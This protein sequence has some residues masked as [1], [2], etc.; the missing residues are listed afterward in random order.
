MDLVGVLQT[1]VFGAVYYIKENALDIV[2][3]YLMGKLFDGLLLCHRKEHNFIGDCLTIVGA[4]KKI[5]FILPKNLEKNDIKLAL[6]TLQT[7]FK[8]LSRNG[9]CIYNKENNNWIM[10]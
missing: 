10:F 7:T 5:E 6:S 3:G 8:K 2:I 9:K 1:I 4:D